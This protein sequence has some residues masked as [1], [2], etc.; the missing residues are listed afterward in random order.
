MLKSKILYV[1]IAALALAVVGGGVFFLA[2]RSGQEEATP[3]PS[4]K[5]EMVDCGQAQDPWCFVNRMNTCSPVTVRMT[6][7]DNKTQ[8]EL[9]ILGVED[10]KCHFQRKIDNALNLDCYFPKGTLDMDTLDQTFGNDK[11]LQDVVDS[12]CRSGGW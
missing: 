1:I 6:G 8:I 3:T 9:T 10:E 2:N 5:S 11:G 4:A 12:A 7:S